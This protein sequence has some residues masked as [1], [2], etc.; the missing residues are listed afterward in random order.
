MDEGVISINDLT[1]MPVISFR[2]QDFRPNSE[3][4]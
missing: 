3:T 1:L 4:P 2:A